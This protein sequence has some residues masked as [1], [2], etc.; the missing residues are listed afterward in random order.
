MHLSCFHSFRLD[1]VLIGTPTVPNYG[2][3]H[4]IAIICLVLNLVLTIPVS[5]A[6]I[7]YWF[8]SFKNFFLFAYFCFTYC[9]SAPSESRGYLLA[10]TNGGLNQMR[11]GVHIYRLSFIKIYS[12]DIHDYLSLSITMAVFEILKFYYSTLF[13]RLPKFLFCFYVILEDAC[14]CAVLYGTIY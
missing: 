1:S 9:F 4:Q 2:S 8:A 11:A 12:V 13:V 6:L 5:L 3:L 7:S 14:S 10:H